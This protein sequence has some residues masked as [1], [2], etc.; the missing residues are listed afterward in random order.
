MGIKLTPPKNKMPAKSPVR[1]MANMDDKQFKQFEKKVNAM[2]TSAGPVKVAALFKAFSQGDID[3]T[4]Y[5]KQADIAKQLVP[6]VQKERLKRDK[7]RS[8]PDESVSPKP[9]KT[10]LGENIGRSV[11]KKAGQQ[12]GL[13]STKAV[14]QIKK[15]TDEEKKRKYKQFR[16]NN[17]STPPSVMKKGGKVS[18]NK[19]GK[20]GCSHNRLY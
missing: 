2:G 1:M 14:K 6:M 12:V 5:F 10:K 18:Y 9:K 3:P 8:M 15:T 4:A 16:N 19:G 7:G 17:P 11:N 13:S 20:I